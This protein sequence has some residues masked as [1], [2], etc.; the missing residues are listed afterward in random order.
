M[1]ALVPIEGKTLEQGVTE[2]H[3]I[4]IKK[5]EEEREGVG[6]TLMSWLSLASLRAR[7]RRCSAVRSG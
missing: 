4:S 2:L 1:A 5:K 3:D 7:L 6:E